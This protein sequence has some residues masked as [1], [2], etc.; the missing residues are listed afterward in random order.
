MI[1]SDKKVTWKHSTFSVYT[2]DIG[3]TGRGYNRT[4]IIKQSVMVLY[5]YEVEDNDMHSD[6]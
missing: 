4:Y 6:E 1:S 3:E 5:D 2:Q